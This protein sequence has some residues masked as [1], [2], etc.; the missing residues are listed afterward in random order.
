[1]A[2]GY[3]S[4]IYLIYKN[5]QQVRY[6]SQLSNEEEPL[7][8][9]YIRSILRDNDGNIW[10]GGFYYLR[11]FNPS[12]GKRYRY[13][14]VY[15]ITQ[16]LAKDENTLWV[17]TINGI[18]I[19]DKQKKCMTPYDTD[20]EIGCINMIYQ[21]PDRRL[22]YFGTYGNGLFIINNKHMQ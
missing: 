12:N 5:T 8:D 2:G 16:L 19:F 7:P 6:I 17:G 10:T 20:T 11:M 18:Y 9:K 15:P 13:D 14:T 4:G 3:M 1:M 22:T 21:T